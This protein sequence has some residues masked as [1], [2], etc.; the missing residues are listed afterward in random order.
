VCAWMGCWSGVRLDG[1]LVSAMHLDGAAGLTVALDGL[2]VSVRLDGLLVFCAW[3]PAV[4]CDSDAALTSVQM[5][6]NRV[7]LRMLHCPS[8]LVSSNKHSVQ[9]L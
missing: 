9:A 8:L 1:L 3:A 5:H 6:S 2:L 7:S 4:Q